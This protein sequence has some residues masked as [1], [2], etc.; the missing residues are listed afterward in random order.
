MGSLV[1]AQQ[2]EPKKVRSN[3]SVLFYSSRRLAIS[4]YISR[5]IIKGGLQPLYLITHQRVF[6]CGIVDIHAFGVLV[7]I[8]VHPFVCRKPS[9][10]ITLLCFLRKK[11]RN[12]YVSTLCDHR[13]LNPCLSNCAP[14]ASAAFTILC[15]ILYRYNIRF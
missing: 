4:L 10:E 9:F 7:P 15:V 13:C 14:L 2:G 6:S 1:Q 12:Y 3:R 8:R 11:S 5:Y